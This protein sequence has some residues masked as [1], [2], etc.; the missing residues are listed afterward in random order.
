MDVLEDLVFS[1]I[2]KREAELVDQFAQGLPVGEE[3]EVVR[4]LLRLILLPC[5]PTRPLPLN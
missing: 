3:L 2:L 5:A 4:A 1:I